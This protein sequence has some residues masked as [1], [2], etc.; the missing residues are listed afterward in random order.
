MLCQAGNTDT[1]FH[2]GR[3]IPGANS[4]FL[5]QIGLSVRKTL[6][7]DEA[8]LKDT[9]ETLGNPKSDFEL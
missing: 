1:Q 4:K 6:L 3:I 9:E 5:C 8:T 7:T 2:R